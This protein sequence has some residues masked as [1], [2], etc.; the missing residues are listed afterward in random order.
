MSTKIR[1]VLIVI[2]AAVF[3][4]C[5]YRIRT[6]LREYEK[7]DEAYTVLEGY[8]SFTTTETPSGEEETLSGM[9]ETS[10]QA[11]QETQQDTPQGERSLGITWPE[12]DFEGLRE[13][14]EYVVGWLYCE[15]TVINYPVTQYNNNKYFL[16]YRFDGEAHKAGCLFVDAE[17][18]K[19]F[20]DPNTIIY[21]HHMKNGSMFGTLT[22]YKKQ[23]Y[24]EDHPKM[25]F[26]TPDQNYVVRLFAGYVCAADGEAWRIQFAHDADRAAWVDSA[27]ERSTF[28]SGL[29]PTANDRILTLSTCSY[30]FDDARYV[31]LG[32][33]EP[34]RG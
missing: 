19:D 6:E 29:R 5:L 34:V 21:G 16:H 17:N 13:I 24:Y 30:E 10:A 20:S 11:L 4:F 28:D 1:R 3:C 8:V 2:C 32:I 9:S 26:L 14:N 31:L 12:V 7:A 33:L 22:N 27:L 15:D 25:L 23:E 18:Q